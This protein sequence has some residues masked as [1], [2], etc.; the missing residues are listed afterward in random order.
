MILGHSLK[1]LV[2]ILLLRA[3][4][5]P[6]FLLQ[7]TAMVLVLCVVLQVNIHH[8]HHLDLQ[9]QDRLLVQL[10]LGL[11]RHLLLVLLVLEVL[12]VTGIG[13]I[14]WEGMGWISRLPLL[15]TIDRGLLLVRWHD[16]MV[17][18][19]AVV[20]VPVGMDVETHVTEADME[21]PENMFSLLSLL[22]SS[23]SAGS[24]LLH[25]ISSTFKQSLECSFVILMFCCSSKSID[26]IC[27]YNI[28][29]T[30]I[31]ID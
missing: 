30:Y 31:L 23:N 15:D 4:I 22:C 7:A 5:L 16:I 9:V 28:C 8:H 11:L 29:A 12:L 10:L 21:D 1:D 19:V 20:A 24:F 6:M 2:K 3:T 25:F 26:F 13:I 17:E 18:E 27:R 14:G